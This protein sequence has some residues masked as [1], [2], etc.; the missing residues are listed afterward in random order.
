MLIKDPKI[1]PIQLQMLIDGCAAKDRKC[2]KAI[3]EFFAPAMMALCMRY[4][5]NQEESEE[6]LQDG[7]TQAFLYIHQFKNTG[8][9]G[10]WLRKIIINTAL[11]KYRGKYNGFETMSL[12][13]ELYHLHAPPSVF[14]Y[15]NEKDLIRMVQTL[16]PAYRM[17]F[18]L[19]VFEGLKHREIADLLGISEGTSK[20]NLF[21]ARSI[22]KKYLSQNIKIAK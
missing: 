15:L 20:S 5:R 1:S 4:C 13:E 21:D 9:F 11:H 12:P 7:F 10:G 18:N 14:D 2:Q 17:V 6:V 22:L 3:Y 8:S 16:P 19:Y